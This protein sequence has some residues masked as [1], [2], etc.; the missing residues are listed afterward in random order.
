MLNKA[1][2]LPKLLAMGAFSSKGYF[3]MQV[4]FWHSTAHSAAELLRIRRIRET[5]SRDVYYFHE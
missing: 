4:V 2:V 1:R 5:Q 3:D